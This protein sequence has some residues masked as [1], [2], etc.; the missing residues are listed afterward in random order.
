ME[1][2]E[3]NVLQC[4]PLLSDSF[5]IASP[6]AVASECDEWGFTV[7]EVNRYAHNT[8]WALYCINLQAFFNVTFNNL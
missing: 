7:K 4:L 1:A 2:E 5:D 6:N 3:G 8:F